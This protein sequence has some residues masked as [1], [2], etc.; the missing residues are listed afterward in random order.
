MKPLVIFLTIYLYKYH[1]NNFSNI[2]FFYICIEISPKTLTNTDTNIPLIGLKEDRFCQAFGNLSITTLVDWQLL[3]T[4]GPI[5]STNRASNCR[6][7]GHLGLAVLSTIFPSGFARV[8]F[9]NYRTEPMYY[10]RL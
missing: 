1:D 10:F 5:Q 3:A 9:E 7:S 4:H 8:V 6:S 2:S